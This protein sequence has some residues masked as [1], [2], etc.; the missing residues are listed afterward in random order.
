MVAPG[1]VR[2][3]PVPAIVVGAVGLL[4]IGAG[5]LAP[6]R[7]AM[8]AALTDRSV[9]ALQ[10]GGVTGA[11]VTFTGRDGVVRVA[12]ADAERAAAIVRGQKGVRTA[13]VL[14]P[15]TPAP[16]RPGAVPPDAAAPTGPPAT[17]GADQSL[18]AGIP[19]AKPSA[20]TPSAATPSAATP[21][22]AA[23]S[24]AALPSATPSAGAPSDAAL[25]GAAPSGGAPS[26]G[27]PSGVVESRVVQEELGALPPIT[28]LAGSGT[29]TPAGQVAVQEAAVTLKTAPELPV[30]VE[31]HTDDDG[32][33]GANLELSRARAR[34]VLKTLRM[35]GVPAARMSAE[36]YGASRPKVPGAGPESRAANRRVEIVV[37]A[38]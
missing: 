10:A 21:S 5:Q 4:V 20:A 29:L 13:E 14:V 23:P 32:P 16:E 18:A 38:G 6:N 1:R 35:Y 36:G 22:A 33:V 3:S 30:R 11:D 19:A 15:R 27:A 9:R 7:H 17:S 31:G 2:R 24:D 8:E 34:T 28:F 26:G 25:S 12:A 37:G